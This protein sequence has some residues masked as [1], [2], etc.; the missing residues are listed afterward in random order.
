MKS[1]ILYRACNLNQA[2]QDELF[3]SVKKSIEGKKKTLMK[4]ILS[5]KKIMLD[6]GDSHRKK[7]HYIYRFI[8]QF[9]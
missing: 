5:F 6:E 8:I 9:Y 7:R 4:I 1:K 2:H 3:E